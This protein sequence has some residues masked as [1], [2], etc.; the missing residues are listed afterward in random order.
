V[1]FH[2]FER[3]VAEY[4]SRFER[5]YGFLRPIVKD[6]VERYL[7][8]GN[9]RCGFA[10]IR[11]PR[12][13]AEHLLMF[14]CKTRGFCPSCHSKRLEEWGEWMRETLLLDVPHR[15]VVFV[16]PKMLRVFFKFKRKLLGDLCRCA[17]RALLLYL[18]AAAGTALEPGIVAIQTFGD[19]INLHPHLHFLVTEGGVDG[20]GLFYKIPRIDDLRLA[21]LFGR[22][23]L[24]NLVRRELLSP[25]W[26]ERILSWRHTGFSVHSRVRAKTKIEAERV[27][28]YMIR[29]LLSLE[30]L[31]LDELRGQVCYR[32]GKEA[33]EVEG[34]DYLE[35]I[36]RVTSHIPDKGQ[37]TVRYYRLYANAHRGKI[38]KASL[39]AFPL[40]IV[41]TKLRP[42]PAK[43][44]AEMIRKVYEV[45]PMVCPQCGG[46][47]KV[48]AFLTDYPVV[49]RIINHLK[50]SF[51]ADRPPPPH[52]AYQELLM[53]AETSTEYFS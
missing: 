30:R 10:R 35:F 23:V 36:A 2:H 13:R 6:V 26:A 8:C 11:C 29:P 20:A 41:E 53:A 4:E 27:G 37:V 42:I 46:A 38:R 45:D 5:D 22:E 48:I 18:E 3:F 21:S 9:P 16:I 33:R 52:I 49:D 39:A 7:D 17:E 28:K 25:E 34:M 47:M 19:R 40:R 44:W 31:S 50:L 32:Y 51:V 14:S 24:A 12:C 1:L 43:G 15:Q